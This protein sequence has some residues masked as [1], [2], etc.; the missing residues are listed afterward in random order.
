MEIW[1]G[2]WN[3]EEYDSLMKDLNSLKHKTK[4][5]DN[6]Y[7][8]IRNYGIRMDALAYGMHYFFTI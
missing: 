4:T 3:P 8:V 6:V 7:R 2:F 1:K 5:F